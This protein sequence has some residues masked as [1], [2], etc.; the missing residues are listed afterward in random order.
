[1]S[2]TIKGIFAEGVISELSLKV[3]QENLRLRRGGACRQGT[4]LGLT[5]PNPS[6]PVTAHVFE[7]NS[8][9]ISRACHTLAVRSHAGRGEGEWGS[10]GMGF[11]RSDREKQ[12]LSIQTCIPDM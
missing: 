11:N 2:G 3:E 8:K 4:I 1:M 9:M 6:L 10:S 12:P 5:Q 7:R